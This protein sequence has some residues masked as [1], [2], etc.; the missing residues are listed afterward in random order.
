M[1]KKIAKPM[2]KRRLRNG[3]ASR[4]RIIML[5][6]DTRSAWPVMRDRAGLSS[7]IATF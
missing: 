3:D 7:N 1:T 6:W 4:A 5:S 2:Q